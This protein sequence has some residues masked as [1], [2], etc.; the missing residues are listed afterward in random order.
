[1]ACPGVRYEAGCTLAMQQKTVCDFPD[2]Y[3]NEGILGTSARVLYTSEQTMK[4]D[5]H[6]YACRTVKMAGTLAPVL[7]IAP[8]FLHRD[9][10]DPGPSGA[11]FW[12]LVRCRIARHGQLETK[13]L[14][15]L[16]FYFVQLLILD[17]FQT[18]I[19]SRLA[20]A[21]VPYEV[22]ANVRACTT[23]AGQV[24]TDHATTNPL[25]LVS[26]AFDIWVLGTAPDRIL[27]DA[28]PSCRPAIET[29]KSF[30]AQQSA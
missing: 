5:G 26:M 19:T 3:L 4:T 13:M 9:Y 18:E 6:W 11:S 29:A 24:I 20:K 28:V 1:M 7:R 21:N 14:S 10:P 27:S 8:G 12:L 23:S 16:V 15:A 22:V 17:P 25:P 2:I 30:L